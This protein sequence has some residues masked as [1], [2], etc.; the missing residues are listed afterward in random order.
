MREYLHCVPHCPGA[1][2]LFPALYRCW[3]SDTLAAYPCLLA[4]NNCATSIALKETIDVAQWFSARKQGQ[5]FLAIVHAVPIMP[6][7]Q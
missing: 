2:V 1:A 4:L 7:A 6:F 3:Q 5:A